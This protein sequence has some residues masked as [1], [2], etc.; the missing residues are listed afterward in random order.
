M[1]PIKFI[2]IILC[3]G[4]LCGTSCEKDKDKVWT[5][6]PPE[7][8]TGA[9]TIGCL[10]DGQLWATGKLQGS[11]KFPAMR[12]LYIDYGDYVHLDFYAYGKTGG[13]GFFVINPQL[14]ANKTRFSSRF[15][16]YPGCNVSIDEIAGLYITKMDLDKGI[17]SG[18]FAF[19][20]PCKEDADKVLH[21]TEGRF[22]M[23]LSVFTNRTK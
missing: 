20:V 2:I 23:Y 12:A 15:D 11:F 16:L 10:V 9:N 4:L 1:K 19:D 7:T 13:M 17:I 8:Q 5:E 6:L 3:M 22:D 21:I 18:R 14:G